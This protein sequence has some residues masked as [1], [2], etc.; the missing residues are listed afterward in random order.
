MPVIA[1]TL[2]RGVPTDNI[3]LLDMEEGGSTY[4]FQ[5]TS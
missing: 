4:G 3:N 2:M 1:G 5:A